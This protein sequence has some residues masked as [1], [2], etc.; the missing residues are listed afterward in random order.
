MVV[1]DGIYNLLTGR[2]ELD[3]PGSWGTFSPDS[4]LAA[5]GDGGV[6]EV[7]TWD[8]VANIPIPTGRFTPFS[9]DSSLIATYDDVSVIAVYAIPEGR[10]VFTQSGNSASFSPSGEFLLVAGDAGGVYEM[11]DWQKVFE[12]EQPYGA[13]FSPDSAHV[14]V[15]SDGVYEVST[16][17]KI[18]SISG[19]AR[20]SSDGSLLAAENGLYD[21]RRGERIY[22][23]VGLDTFSPDN[24]LVAGDNGIYSVATGQNLISLSSDYF[25]FNSDGTLFGIPN[26]VYDTLTEDIVLEVEGYPDFTGPYLVASSGELSCTVYR[27]S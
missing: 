11:R 1:D 23:I 12:F 20:F 16:G 25:D 8:R 26:A 15:Y 14:V 17:R 6:Y 18:F 24:E 3:F 22:N 2:K 5:I 27:A 19:F 13:E 10:R 7:G 21:V 4:T 9:P